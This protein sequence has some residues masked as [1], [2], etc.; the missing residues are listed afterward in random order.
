MPFSKEEQDRIGALL[1]EEGVQGCVACGFQ[2]GFLF[3]DVAVLVT[4]GSVG[5][6]GETNISGLGVVPIA[7]PRCG[8]MMLLDDRNLPI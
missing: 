8:Y 2:G 7:C 3:G 4:P 1:V 5:P 6:Q